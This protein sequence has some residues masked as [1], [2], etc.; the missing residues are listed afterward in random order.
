MISSIKKY[1]AHLLIIFMLMMIT[2]FV[3]YFMYMRVEH[4]TDPMTTKPMT[5]NPMTTTS[6][7]STTNPNATAPT[8]TPAYTCGPPAPVIPVA[9]MSRYFGIGFNIYQ[10]NS[11]AS[12][13]NYVIEYTPTTSN[14]TLGGVFAISSDGLL[15]IKLRNDEDPTQ[16]WNINQ[17]IDSKDSQYPVPYYSILPN[18]GNTHALHYANGNLSLRIYNESTI[19]EG[20]KWITSQNIV[21]RGIPVLNYSPG[22]LFTAEFD[23]YSTTNSITQNN[24]NNQ[25]SQQV[26][27]VVTAVKSGIQ[28][29]LTQLGKS[30]PSGQI[31]ASSLGNKEMPLNLNINLSGSASSISGTTTGTSSK[32]GFAN[33][34]GA[35]SSTDVLKSLDKYESRQGNSTPYYSNDLL[36]QIS[37]NSQG[38][39][40]FDI[41]DYTGNRVGSCN[42]KL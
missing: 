19:S 13:P 6:M 18:S 42:C 28:Q 8:T 21:T 10:V 11:S 26:S 2:G 31:S 14:G 29:Y 16:W 9:I 20:H 37:T 30:Q 41:N 5:T 15:T 38:C 3:I 36:N 33:I 4:F 23:P 24:L 12:I 32:S 40:S 17:I 1:K 25:N 34:G 35:T 27:D 39:K 7:T 22:S